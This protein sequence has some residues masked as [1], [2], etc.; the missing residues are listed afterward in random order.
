MLHRRRRRTRLALTVAVLTV[1]SLAG[2]AAGATAPAAGSTAATSSGIVAQRG[3]RST[4]VAAV[5][6]ALIAAGIT[7]RGGVDGIFGPGTAAAVSDYQRRRGLSVTGVVDV[8][9]A[10]AL[11]VVEVQAEL[12]R[13]SQGAAV[14][15]LQ[16]QLI[17]VG[18]TPTG[19]ADGRFGPGTEAAVRSFQSSRGLGVTGQVD[20]ATAQILANAAAAAT[21][22]PATPPPATPSPTAL[23]QAGSRGAIVV[24]LQRDLIAVGLRPTGGA[25]GIFGPSTTARLTEFQ[26]RAGLAATGVYDQATAT[27]L[28]AA[29]ATARAT[30]PPSPA[31]ATGAVTLATFPMP[32]RCTFGDTFGAPRSGGRR[33]EGV[34]ILAPRGT[35]LFAVQDGTITKRQTGAPLAGNALWL[36]A[37]DG[38]YFFYAHLDGFASGIDRGV[39]VRAGDVIGYVG[40]TGNAGIPHLHFE[41][42]P[43]GGAAVNPYPIVKA[44]SGC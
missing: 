33:H 19:G 23:A 12:R 3:D 24:T 29:A 20:P 44:V 35:P 34:D 40:R 27:A 25:D 32:V 18:L 26:R 1:L 28:S 37:A 4:V 16:R 11:G 21:K 30:P 8:A 2:P 41:V 43:R 13:G 10:T 6:R 31:P 9:T 39:R 42:H 14:V 36:T 38:T 17:A 22:P 5:Q 7:V 15:T